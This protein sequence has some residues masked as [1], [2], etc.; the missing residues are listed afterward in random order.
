MATSAADGPIKI[1]KRI[2]K[3]LHQTKVVI[4]RLPP[5]LTEEKLLE[6]LPEV[7]PYT[8]F[9][10]T[11][12]DPTLGSLSF[13]R[14]YFCFSDEASILPFRDKYDGM[15]L[16]S[17]KG[18]K[19]RAVVEYAPYQGMPKK[20]RRKP[21]TRIGTIED[22]SDY[23]SFLETA[24]EK[25]TPFT[26]NELAAY[27]DTI[28]TNKVA[29][30]QKTPLIS[31]LLDRR[32]GRKRS[33]QSS[34]SKKKHS[35]ESSKPPKESRK[36]AGGSKGSSKSRTESK[37]RKERQ[38]K[39]KEEVPTTKDRP[40]S[41]ERRSGREKRAQTQPEE[42]G[43]VREGK[44]VKEEGEKKAKEPRIKN[45]DRP[46]QAI[47]SPRGK[48]RNDRER[49]DSGKPHDGDTSSHHSSSSREGTSERKSG[50]DRGSRWKDDEKPRRGQGG[51]W[52]KEKRDR[53]GGRR[54]GHRKPREAYYDR[55]SKTHSSGY[56]E[57]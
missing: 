48:Q 33:K 53:D 37:E 57:K 28:G 45:K 52:D 47:Y 23:K 11:T 18:T 13:S 26:M 31:Y 5:D 22:D 34:E 35:K 25:P 32:G 3:E 1:S 56:R 16:E 29:E 8:F 2:E 7:P 44:E 46:D 17:E 20:Q 55:D 40:T 10:F 39:G 21:D 15:W 42:N 27:I 43:E 30:V 50:R 4:R 51:G 49:N 6:M 12:G 36:D 14:A 9:Y 54:D 38:E 41:S 24:E 19:Y